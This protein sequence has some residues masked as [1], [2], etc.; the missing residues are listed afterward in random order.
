MREIAM[1]RYEELFSELQ[2]VVL[3]RSRW[4]DSLLPP[5]IFLILNA[6]SAYE[7]AI[8]GS[9]L[10]A[11]IIG[12]YRMLRKETLRFAFGGAGGVI[13][14][15]L[16]ARYVGGAQGY[17]LPGII[18]GAFTT[19][20]CIISVFIKRPLVAW[21]SY[22]TRRW[23]L[24]WYWHPGVRPAY[25]EVTIAWALFFG[26]RTLF[27]FSLFQQQAAG[28]L[29]IIQLLTGWPALIILLIISYLYGMWRLQNLHGP[30]VEEFISDAEPPW[31]GQKRGF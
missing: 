6:I 10:A 13:L 25:S 16:L 12:I 15:G 23:P 22:I 26:L 11:V 8:A 30:S 18:S 2:T 1:S 21:T 24:E 19:L 27:Q 17:F 14:A 29:G 28:T 5:I 20:I 3:S 4:L 31:Q 7:I 9:L